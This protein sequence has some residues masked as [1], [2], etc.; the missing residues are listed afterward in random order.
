MRPDGDR[1]ANDR[2]RAA[3]RCV[4]A[5][6]AFA[7]LMLLLAVGLASPTAATAESGKALG[8]L[9]AAAAAPEQ[10]VTI[11]HRTNSRTNPYNQIAVAESAAIEGHAREHTGPIFGPEV[12]DWGDIIP[13]ID[14]GLPLGL[15]WPEGR[16][17]L[18]NGCEMEPD[19]GPLPT[20]SI[21]DAECVGNS[22]SISVTVT[23]EAE[24]TQPATFEILVDG[25]VVQTV[26]PLAPGESETVVLVD[27]PGGTFEARED[28]V[29]TVAVRSEGEIIA[30]RVVTADCDPAP[31]LVDIE[32]ELTCV[33]G[34]AQGTGTATNNSQAPVTVTTTVDG[35]PVGGA[36]IVDPGATETVTVDLSPYE[37]QTIEAQVLVD[38]VVVA[39]YTVTPDCVAPQ[40][41]PR[42]AVA[43]QVCPP[44][45]STVTLANDGDPDST[46]V[47]AVTIDG[48]VVQ[49]SAPLY[50]G[51]VT[52]IVGD[53]SG[54]E[55]QTVTVGLLSNGELL[56]RRT[57]SV[58]CKIDPPS[59]APGDA[60]DELPAVGAPFRPGLVALGLGLVV[61]GALLCASGLRRPR[62]PG[63]P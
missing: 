17:I 20:A 54:F 55:D 34:A 41:A 32:A 52:T 7:P 43:G 5:A 29:T 57:I 15:N 3:R 16:A 18:E 11:C 30:S 25:A 13:P 44:P 8:S 24:A 35:S 33:G 4:A 37:D 1:R 56:G 12:E 40:P 51:D 6:A 53:L 42:V 36:T 22:A 60:E 9:A 50:G 59:L 48:R 19:V 21:G 63:R 46:V 58:N 28:Q 27:E 31:P 61:V 39:T 62:A 14:P 26:G 2:W 49:Q 23:N 45:S 47:F 10:K 38:G